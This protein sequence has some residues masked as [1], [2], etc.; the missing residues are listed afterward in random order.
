MNS[1]FLILLLLSFHIFFLQST[2]SFLIPAIY[3]ILLYS[4]TFVHPFLMPI[5]ITSLNSTLFTSFS[6]LIPPYS[7]LKRML[8]DDDDDDHDDD[9]A[10]AVREYP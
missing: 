2:S 4:C 10:K 8:E 9:D 5:F 1:S 7:F 6:S 3:S